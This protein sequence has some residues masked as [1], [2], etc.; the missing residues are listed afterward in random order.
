MIHIIE[1]ILLHIIVHIIIHIIS[2]FSHLRAIFRTD[3]MESTTLGIFIVITAEG[4]QNAGN[5]V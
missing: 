3:K 5:K 2:C 4:K 1:R